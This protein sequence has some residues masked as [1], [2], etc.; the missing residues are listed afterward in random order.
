MVVVVVGRRGRRSLS[1]EGD[2][3]NLRRAQRD[4]NLSVTTSLLH[5]SWVYRTNVLQHVS[6]RRRRPVERD[7]SLHIKLEEVRVLQSLPS[8]SRQG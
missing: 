4:D 6:E 3:V 2:I 5:V 8:M 7:S 1:F